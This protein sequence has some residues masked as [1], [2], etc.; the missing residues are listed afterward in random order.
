M[1]SKCERFPI[2]YGNVYQR[3]SM[4][5]RRCDAFHYLTNNDLLV[6]LGWCS[7]RWWHQ[8]MPLC[9][10]HPALNSSLENNFF[11]LFIYF[12]FI[13]Y[14]IKPLLLAYSIEDETRCLMKCIAQELLQITRDRLIGKVMF[15]RSHSTCESNISRRRYIR[16][17]SFWWK[18]L[19][20]RPG[21]RLY[22]SSS[23]TCISSTSTCTDTRRSSRNQWLVIG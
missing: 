23:P 20:T 12:K 16:S 15:R 11:K 14:I 3:S 7:W 21:S 8:Y 18:C 1:E 17:P 2:S 19:L 10:F 6:I 22:P 5:C 13:H 9:Y 4:T